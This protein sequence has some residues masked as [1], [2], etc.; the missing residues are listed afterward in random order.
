MKRKRWNRLML[1]DSV[2]VT[3][4]G[5]LAYGEHGEVCNLEYNF[6][7][8]LVAITVLAP[9]QRYGFSRL[10]FRNPRSL[11]LGHVLA[12]DYEVQVD[13]RTTSVPEDEELE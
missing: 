8:K 12:M 5:S 1:G 10:K 11:E 7:G 13:A 3:H 4:E 2:T 6:A 9:T